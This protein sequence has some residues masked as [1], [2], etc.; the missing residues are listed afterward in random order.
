MLIFMFGG[1]LICSFLFGGFRRRQQDPRNNDATPGWEPPTYDVP[2][3]SP[4]S[5]FRGQS[6]ELRK[7]LLDVWKEDS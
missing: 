5:E 1:V 2:F 7:D 4:R 6:Y 3:Q